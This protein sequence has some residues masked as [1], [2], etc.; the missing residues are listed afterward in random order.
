MNQPDSKPLSKRTLV[1]GIVI[2]CLGT[3]V[4]FLVADQRQSFPAPV[5]SRSL[6]EA[7]PSDRLVAVAPAADSASHPP[8][9]AAPASR[10]DFR[11]ELE[12][13]REHFEK[14]IAAHPYH[15]RP[16][17]SKADWKKMPKQD[18][19]D[20]AAE[21]DFLLTLDPATQQVPIE[22][23]YAA[24]EEATQRISF[25]KAIEDVSWVERGP[26]NVAGRTRALTFDP[27]DPTASKVWAGGVGGGLWYSN[28]LFDASPNWIHVDGFWDNIAVNCIAFNPANTQEIY[29][30]T[31]EG[32]YNQDALQ[33][34]GIWK[35]A[36][37]GTT[38]NRLPGTDPG[39]FN[40]AS[41]WHYINK[42]VI[43]NDGT[44]FAATRAWFINRGGIMR[45]TDGGTTWTKV[46]SVF[47][48]D[49]TILDHAA[50]LEVAANGDVYATFGV[51]SQGKVFKSLHSANGASGTWTDLSTQIGVG[52]TQRIE[53]ACAP[54][55]PNIIYAVARSGPFL[56]VLGQDVAWFKKSTDGGVSWT[57]RTIPL[58]REQNCTL[59]TQHFTRGQAWYD[60]ILA[61]HPTNPDLVLAGGID[62]HRTTDGGTTWQGISYWTGKCLPYVHADQHAIQFRP[63]ASNEIIVGTDG[64]VHYSSNAGNASATPTF[65]EK[66]T[67][68]NVTQFYACA[69]KNEA[70]SHY[71]L[72]G[73]Q[74]NGTQ[75]FTKPQA[76]STQEAT[77]GDG[78]FCHID[79]V[80]PAIQLTAVVY[81]RYFRSLDGGV[82]FTTFYNNQ[83]S[84]SFINPT[85]YDSQRKILYCTANPDSLRRLSNIDATPTDTRFFLDLG[86]T[87]L[88]A[89]RVSPYQDV[90]FIGTMGGRIFKVTNAS[91]ASPTFQR[92]DNGTVPITAIGAISCIEVGADDD[93]L[94]ITFSNYGVNSV[95]ETT[96]GGA[97]W[98]SKEGNLPDIPVRWALYNPENRNE[99]LLAT[100][101]GVWSADNF[102][103]G[104]SAAPEWEPTN[105]NLA[106]TRATM[107]KY[108]PADKMVIVSTHGRGLFTT[109]VFVGE[110]VA[111]FVAD[112][113]SACDGSLAAQFTDASLKAK[114][115]A[116]DVD[117]DGL[118]DYTT[119][120]PTHTYADPGIY[121]VSLTINDGASIKIRR[122]Y[123]VV[124]AEAPR[125]T[126]ACTN[127]LNLNNPFG[128]GL[129]RVA[130]ADIDHTTPHQDGPYHDYSCSQATQLFPNTTYQIT[131]RTGTTNSEGVAVYI[132]YNENGTFE[133]GELVT[134][135]AANKDGQRTNSFTTPA[136]AIKNKLL[137]MRVVSRY[138]AVPT[139]A[140]NT[141]NYGQSE[142]Y[143]VLFTDTYLWQGLVST[144]W[145]TPANWTSGTL[146]TAS[147]EV[148]IPQ[149]APLQPMLASNTAVKSVQIAPGASLSMSAG[150][151]LSLQN[152]LLAQGEVIVL[153]ATDQT[154]PPT[155]R[156][157]ARLTIDVQGA[158][159]TLSD[160]MVISD[161]LRMQSGM[162]NLNGF[163]LDLGLTGH[164]R[165]DRAANAIV[166]DNT[167]NL[168]Q[169]SPGGYIRLTQRPTGALLSE[170]GGSGLSLQNAGTVSIDRYHY[171]V[172]NFSL[173]KIY[174]LTGTPANATM[175][176]AYAPA[177][178]AGIT[179]GPGL[180]LWRRGDDD[181]WA[182]Q[183]GT[184]TEAEVS[185]VELDNVSQFSAW[186]VG[187]VN[188]GLPV[189]LRYFEA[190]RVSPQHVELR[191]QTA[192]EINNHGFT[193]EASPSAS[194]F[195]SIAFLPGQGN[196]SEPETYA[197]T[198]LTPRSSYYRLKQTDFDGTVT[199][200]AMVFVEGSPDDF[201]VNFYPNPVE[202][203]L[204]IRF[205]N[206]LLT[207]TVVTVYN[208]KGQRL[209]AGRAA[210]QADEL[211]IYMGAFPP[212]VYLIRLGEGESLRL[213]KV[214]K[215]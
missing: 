200:S 12:Q 159:A 71:F 11:A 141:G 60:L 93:Q 124:Q 207:A 151:T 177:E 148:L 95:W 170:I 135:F 28:N 59:G 178:L 129:Y 194:D 162:L 157:L 165:E 195:A 143:G 19:P 111:D 142:D 2:L 35:S 211:K 72:A 87:R 98:Y 69:V 77:G 213:K 109:D 202:D 17:R 161:T 4:F 80:D 150:G 96:D 8:I 136:A 54:S 180:R 89:L 51:F 50:D 215:K 175:R 14:Y 86:G 182:N 208:S 171:Q 82:T 115:W 56:S 203:E 110:S 119:Q 131:V 152:D 70:N 199:Y 166:T 201:S 26:N 47:A 144:D 15:N 90:L 20:M 29:V 41:D 61:V 158:T 32:W 138:D 85:D 132:D 74:D 117:N 130:I 100:E 83:Q 174:A 6:P 37:G 214:V 172:E 10:F 167:P 40:S 27:N 186:T 128:I 9:A 38:W 134:T 154:L 22:R 197:Y 52:N 58:Y 62:L 7:V 133:A 66:N 146:P 102:G 164:L 176:I 122:D 94:L 168:S 36:D 123:I 179:E 147:S 57:N 125:A 49:N 106:T 68:Y 3:A 25:Q 46:L 64:G 118:T 18:R 198:H 120:N 126:A 92:I 45:S 114:S 105:I 137:R 192:Q 189:T 33:G 169:S 156:K 97:N 210:A 191:W 112:L 91:T 121:S 127:A 1:Y 24:N 21:L 108:R 187:D 163:A 160:D 155:F 116:W 209:Y 76:G 99:V 53:L 5:D 190:E 145:D 48:Q 30:G 184:W 78:G 42:I 101:V 39:A 205:S 206:P 185:Y 79:Q 149:A 183:G 204:T 140:C 23:K 55:D 43:K 34:G 63:D 13:Q 188:V 44:I 103:A 73:S 181:V 81:N 67:G 193:I 75:Q 65:T 139:N 113:R 31:G 173:K 153:G 88:T 107:L 104:T 212:G 196:Q 16:F 84:G